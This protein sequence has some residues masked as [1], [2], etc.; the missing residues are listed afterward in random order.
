M[1]LCFASVTASD[2]EP[3]TDLIQMSPNRGDGYTEALGDILVRAS[4]GVEVGYALHP[5]R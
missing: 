1:P 5:C 2:S 4:L 3:Q